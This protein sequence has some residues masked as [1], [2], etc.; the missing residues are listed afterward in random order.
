MSAARQDG[1]A[2]IRMQ[3]QVIDAQDA[4]GDTIRAWSW[5]SYILHLI[6][7][8]AAVIPGAQVSIVLLIA[9][10]ILDWVKRGDAAGTWQASHF[11]WRI[12]TVWW[13]LVLYLV[14]LPLWLLVIVPGWIAWML[15]SIWFLYRI[16]KGMVRMNEGRSMDAGESE[17]K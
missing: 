15:I 2:P 14:T 10:Q 16:I 7:A 17:A 1:G 8:V 3:D 4:H 11:G 6:V 5:V 13:A 12:R 9:A